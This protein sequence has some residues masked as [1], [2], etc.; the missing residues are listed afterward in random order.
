MAVVTK[1]S[2]IIDDLA[3]E[4]ETFPAGPAI[5][6]SAELLSL[7]PRDE[8]AVVLAIIFRVVD[9]AKEK[10]AAA[11]LAKDAAATAAM[12]QAYDPD[13]LV[14]AAC[15][16]AERIV[17]RGGN[18]DVLVRKLLART[19]C[20]QVQIAGGLPPIA[21][22]NVSQHFDSHFQGRIRHLGKVLGWILHVGFEVL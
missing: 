5:N 22:G 3:Y 21:N 11:K 20:S 6:L 18:V 1:H 8:L 15:N 13:V 17:A 4:T 16:I 14:G 19:T 7:A 2:T 12:Q 10:D 9:A